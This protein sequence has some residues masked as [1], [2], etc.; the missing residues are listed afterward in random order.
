[1]IQNE[2]IESMNLLLSELNKSDDLN[3]KKSII[4]KAVNL[5]MK[6]QEEK[7]KSGINIVFKTLNE[8]Y[9]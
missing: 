6:Y 4:A 1:M 7:I 2:L 8:N 5:G 9:E 3:T